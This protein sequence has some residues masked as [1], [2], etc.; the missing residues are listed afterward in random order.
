MEKIEPTINLEIE[1]P[2]PEPLDS[3]EIEDDGLQQLDAYTNKP[4]PNQQTPPPFES[5]EVDLTHKLIRLQSTAIRA[6]GLVNLALWIK[7]N[8]F[9]EEQNEVKYTG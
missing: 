5:C 4:D 3:S 9:K 8:F 1:K 6:D 7:D 2:K